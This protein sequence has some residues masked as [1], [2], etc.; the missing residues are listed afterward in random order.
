MRGAPCSA[1]RAGCLLVP[2]AAAFRLGRQSPLKSAPAVALIRLGLGTLGSQRAGSRSTRAGASVS[3]TA[4]LL[5]ALGRPGSACRPRLLAPQCRLPPHIL[6]IFCCW[7]PQLVLLSWTLPLCAAAA[8][9]QPPS[10][11]R[12]CRCSCRAPLAVAAADTPT[13]CACA[14]ARPPPLHP[15]IPALGDD[16]RPVRLRDQ[17]KKQLGVGED[18]LGGEGEGRGAACALQVGTRPLLRWQPPP[19]T[20]ASEPNHLVAGRARNNDDNNNN[21]R[22]RRCSLSGRGRTRRGPRWRAPRRRG[23]PRRTW[24][25]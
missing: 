18:N 14:P 25:G 19:P 3:T 5:R 1:R 9:T 23:L 4:R 12:A 8:S 2:R 13:L 21:N 11:L 22:R 17:G 16:A 6:A 24:P 15:Q 20:T 7:S 10:Q